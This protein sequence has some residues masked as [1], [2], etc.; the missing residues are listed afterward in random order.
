[1]GVQKSDIRKEV[2]VFLSFDRP[3][4]H[5]SGCG[6]GREIGYHPQKTALIEQKIL[7]IVLNAYDTDGLFKRFHRYEEDLNVWSVFAYPHPQVR[8]V[9]RSTQQP[10]S[11]WE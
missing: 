1:M 10:P 4:F 3:Y 7:E 2:T 8:R 6:E 5:P 11:H 9:R